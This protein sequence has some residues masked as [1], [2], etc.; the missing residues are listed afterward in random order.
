MNGLILPAKQKRV[1]VVLYIRLRMDEAKLIEIQIDIP[2]FLNK[3]QSV[4]HLS[5]DHQIIE[6]VQFHRKIQRIR[7]H[8]QQIVASISDSFPKQPIQLHFLLLRLQFG[9]QFIIRKINLVKGS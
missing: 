9:H 2:E 8:L 3:T 6:N 4:A 5:D 1:F 7:T